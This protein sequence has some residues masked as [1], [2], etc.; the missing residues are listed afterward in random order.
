V[1]ICVGILILG[2]DAPGRQRGHSRHS[3]PTGT[4]WKKYGIAFGKCLILQVGILA[5]VPLLL[6][7]LWKKCLLSWTFNATKVDLTAVDPASAKTAALRAATGSRTRSHTI[8]I[9]R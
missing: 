1:Q 7:S 4:L 6:V 9:R 5:Q 3:V 8:L 2:A